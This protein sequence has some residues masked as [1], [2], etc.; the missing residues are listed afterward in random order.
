MHRNSTN[1]LT[2]QERIAALAKQSPEMAFTSLA[3]LMDIDWLKGRQTEDC[4]RPL[5]PSREE[6]GPM[7]L[8]PSAL[9]NQRAATEAEPKV[10]WT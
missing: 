2:K 6:Y 3:Y 8:P 10:A 7:V 5:Q 9:T 1:V 4:Q